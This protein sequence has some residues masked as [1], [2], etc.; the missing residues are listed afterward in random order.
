MTVNM[1][2]IIK[3]NPHI[4]THK[5]CIKMRVGLRYKWSY[6]PQVLA[7]L[8]ATE[9]RSLKHKSVRAVSLQNSETK[10]QIDGWRRVS[11]D[12][13]AKALIQT[14]CGPSTWPTACYTG[15]FQKVT[16]EQTNVLL[17][18]HLP[19]SAVQKCKS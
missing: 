14:R 1:D 11:R 8:E 10:C 16:D 18:L 15:R 9:G 3:D 6:I 4:F 12:R 5:L 7:T 13:R 19:A 17:L 2:R